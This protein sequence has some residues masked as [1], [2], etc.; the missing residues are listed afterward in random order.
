MEIAIRDHE[1]P[2]TP[3]GLVSERTT[4]PKFVT[5]KKPLATPYMKP[6]NGWMGW[7]TV[8]G[9]SGTKVI[10]SSTCTEGGICYFN[11]DTWTKG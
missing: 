5:V 11:W 6:K 8:E 3:S 9:S 1:L 10:S 2:P 4:T 7:T